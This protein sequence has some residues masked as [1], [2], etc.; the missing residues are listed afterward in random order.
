MGIPISSVVGV[1][2]AIGATFP[3]RAGFGTLNIVTA[4]SGV[5]GVAER[6]R[7]YQNLDGVVA[8]WPANSEVVSAATAYFGQQPKPTSLKVSTRF[9]SAVGAQL[10]S[11]A[12]AQNAAN[13]ALFTAISTGSFAITIDGASSEDITG[14]DFSASTDLNGVASVIETALQ[15]IA[16]GG[17]T[18]ATCTHDGT[19]FFINSGTTGVTSTISFLTA[20]ATGADVSSLLEMQQGEGTKTPGIAAETITA[21]LNAIQNADTDWYGLL[22]TKE[23]RDG[24]VVNAE[25]AVEA[26]AAW[27]E[28]RIK[29]FGNTT[30]DLDALDSVNE[31]DILSLLKAQNLRRTL[32]TYSSSPNQYPSASI[33]GRAFTV[34]FNQPNSTLTLKFKQGPGITVEQL[35]QNEKAVLDSKRGNAF[36]LVGQSDMY[37]ESRMANNTFFDEVHGI[38]WLQN[39]IQINVFGYLLTRTTKVPYTDKGVA[40]LEQQV[41]NALDEAVRNGLIAPGETIDGRFLPNGYEVNT[42]LVADTNQSDKEARNYNGISFIILGAGAIHGAQINGIFER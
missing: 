15:L 23:V 38:D 5:I 29:V 35:T 13:L 30:N 10:R 26:A 33:L 12:V 27:C 1:S 34:N 21:S 41:I 6:I 28:A 9:P 31:N 40:A 18:A 32:S 20:A 11:G 17:F 2:I 39:A 37:A 36:I 3:A 7:S 19:R 42:V 8:D 24:F 25:D 14:L 4:E 22:F 16:S